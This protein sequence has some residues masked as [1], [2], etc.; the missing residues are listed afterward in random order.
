MVE[1]FVYSK[2]ATVDMFIPYDEKGNAEMVMVPT[3]YK[4]SY[5]NGYLNEI[6][7]KRVEQKWYNI[8]GGTKNLKILCGKLDLSVEYT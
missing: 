3:V 6:G 1:Y 2:Q 4:C 8:D 7:M 5:K